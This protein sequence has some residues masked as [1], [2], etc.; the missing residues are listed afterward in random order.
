MMRIAA[1]ATAAVERSEAM[2]ARSY[3]TGKS[4]SATAR[5]IAADFSA[6]QRLDMQLALTRVAAGLGALASR[7]L[8]TASAPSTLRL[9]VDRPNTFVLA[10]THFGDVRAWRTI[11]SASA[12][13]GEAMHYAVTDDNDV[14]LA[15]PSKPTE[16]L[17]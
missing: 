5:K 17:G 4:E 3:I 11:K 10:A 8:E 2:N 1:A 13:G 15:I 16:P 14:S 6:Q 9:T 7:L 12:P